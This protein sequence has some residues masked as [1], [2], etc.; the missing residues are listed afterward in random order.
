MSEAV[1]K[2][3]ACTGV[4]GGGLFSE[5]GEGEGITSTREEFLLGG[6]KGGVTFL[7]E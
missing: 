1:N 4:D 5:V 6:L 3:S 7:F 2:D